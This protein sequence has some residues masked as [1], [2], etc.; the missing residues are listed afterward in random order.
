VVAASKLEPHEIAQQYPWDEPTCV[1]IVG[2]LR[3]HGGVPTEIVLYEGKILDGRHRYEACMRIGRQPRTREFGSDESDGASPELFAWK[4]NG[5]RRHLTPV[6]LAALAVRANGEVQRAEAK[7][8]MAEGQ[9]SGGPMGGRGNKKTSPQGLEERFPGPKSRCDEESLARTAKEVGSTRG[10]AYRAQAVERAAPEI[11][12]RMLAGEFKSIVEAEREAGV[13][14]PWGR[15]DDDGG[16]D[17]DVDSVR[18]GRGASHPDSPRMLA[19]REREGKVRELHAEGMN[20]REIGE[21]IGMDPAAVSKVVARIGLNKKN[22][23]ERI[24]K[25]VEE[26]GDQAS[27]WC[28]VF[29][30]EWGTATPEQVVEFTKARRALGSALDKFANRLAEA[31]KE[32]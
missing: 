13:A 27:I 11:L 14:Q 5:L 3:A 22:P 16:R 2:H 9:K 26:M 29:K 8:R 12:N 23:L 15:K 10:A 30:S 31:T 32:D 1:G 21:A 6:Q 18:I 28:S 7:A 4:M 25:A 19:A 17:R 24:T 20:R